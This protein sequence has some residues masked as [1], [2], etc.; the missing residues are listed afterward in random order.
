M[1]NFQ[2]GDFSLNFEFDFQN[3]F[4]ADENRV[5][6]DIMTNTVDSTNLF[7]MDTQFDESHTNSSSFFDYLYNDS[8][9]IDDVVSLDELPKSQLV[10]FNIQHS[11]N[12]IQS[13]HDVHDYACESQEMTGTVANQS[14]DFDWTS[15]LDQSPAQSNVA[16]EKQTL[17]CVP[18]EPAQSD[19]VEMV[20]VTHDNGC[21]YQELKTIDLP[22]MYANLDDKFGLLDLKQVDQRIDYSSLPI[23]HRM[24]HSDFNIVNSNA[25]STKRK[26]FLVPMELSQPGAESLFKVATKLQTSPFILNSMLNQCN[27]KESNSQVVLPT[28]PKQIKQKSER[29]LTV[30]EQLQQIHTKEIVLPSIQRNFQRQKRKVPPKLDREKT[31]V[32]YAVEVVVTDISQTDNSDGISIETSAKKPTKPKKSP[33]NAK[34][35]KRAANQVVDQPKSIRRSSKKIK[36]P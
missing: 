36:T 15:V 3:D 8:G 12:V 35:S 10:P 9:T 2:L 6:A 29:Y 33:T 19:L 26:M 34:S 28:R 13:I 24:D 30:N 22:Q 18:V 11:S 16:D 20:S 31:A 21:V 1:D 27:D 25:P 14:V 32:T 17:K 4:T 23:Q 5:I 7:G